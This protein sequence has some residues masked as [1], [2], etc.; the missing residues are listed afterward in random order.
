LS[1]SAITNTSVRAESRRSGF[2]AGF[3]P[4]K[5]ALTLYLMGGKDQ[6]LLA[7]LGEKTMGASCLYIKR[8]DDIHRPRC[9]S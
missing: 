9:R 3:S 8:L 6:K 4:R 2:E 7:G 5:Q 1:A